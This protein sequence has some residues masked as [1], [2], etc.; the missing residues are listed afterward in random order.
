MD[1]GCIFFISFCE[2]RV[3]ALSVIWQQLAGDDA[4]SWCIGFFRKKD[5]SISPGIAFLECS[6]GANYSHQ[7]SHLYI[8]K[9]TIISI[10]HERN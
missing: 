1:G 4:Q 2:F 3:I 8:Y 5:F 6:I 7:M 10:G 9:K